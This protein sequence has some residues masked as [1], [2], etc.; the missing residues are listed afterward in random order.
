MLNIYLFQRGLR[1][2]DNLSLWACLK[3]SKKVLG[4]FCI[5]PRQIR[6]KYA[7]PFALG[8]MLESLRD[9]NKR[10]KKVGS[11]V[12]ILEGLP[13]IEVPKL[14]KKVEAGQGSKTKVWASRDYTPF[15]V[16]RAEQMRKAL[17]FL[18]DG[19]KLSQGY[20]E[21][22]DY[23][24][25][26]QGSVGNKAGKAYGV[27]TPFLNSIKG[28]KI[29]KP[30]YYPS[31]LKKFAK[32]K[33]KF[34]LRKLEK[35]S[36]INGNIMGGR[37]EGLKKL[38]RAAGLGPKGPAG[39][40]KLPSLRDY[41]KCRDFMQYRTTELS[42]YIKF[43]CISPREAY[44]A[45]VKLGGKSGQELKRQL[46]WREFYYQYYAENP[47]KLEWNRKASRTGQQE[48]LAKAPI[49]GIAEFRT[50]PDV[51]RKYAL[52]LHQTGYINNRARLL[53]G[54]YLLHDKK[55]YWKTCDQFFAK[56]L[57]DYDP[58]VNAGNWLWIK[59]QPPF[60]RLKHEVQEKKY[61]K[62]CPD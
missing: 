49:L 26:A 60:R 35:L 15:A 32:Y 25:F 42:A 28:K 52:Q 39:N 12:S 47:K 21:V 61:D 13:H 2:E 20:V 43:G 36:I 8:F 18:A 51:V 54:N 34:S 46:I 10:L 56:R 24:L 31:L 57:I 29:P 37:T 22:E 1:L 27:Y 9:L 58:I 23:I 62:E 55:K 41:H 3:E 11:Q 44:W 40:G 45:F 16:K 53:L 38:R 6:G 19:G 59:K 30:K 4:V 5:D 7:S 17:R 50:M 48:N 33:H 14:A